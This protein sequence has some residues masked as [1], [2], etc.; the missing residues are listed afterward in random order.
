MPHDAVLTH[1]LC[2][3][4]PHD[5]ADMFSFLICMVS[6]LSITKFISQDIS[7]RNRD[8]SIVT[9]DLNTSYLK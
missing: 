7:W 9:A 3:I 6:I 1:L 8:F 2:F 4:T 5:S